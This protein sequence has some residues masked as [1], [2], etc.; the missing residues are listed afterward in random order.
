MIQSVTI[1]NY[2]GESLEFDLDKP[3]K[4]GIYIKKIDGLGPVS[5]NVNM[6]EL[7]S[8]DGA[9]F[10]S[11]R[12]NSRNI[13]IQFGLMFN[14]MIE[15][16]RHVLYRLFPLKGQVLVRVQTDR[17]DLYTT[18]YVET[19]NPD[20]F[21]KEETQQVS[22]LCPTPWWNAIGSH[23]SDFFSVT[24]GFMFPFKND[25]LEDKLLTFGNISNFSEIIID[26]EGDSE[27]GML[28]EIHCLK[29][30]SLGWSGCG[31]KLIN[32]DTDEQLY[33]SFEHQTSTVQ[34]IRAGDSFLISTVKGDKYAV[35]RRN[36]KDTNAINIMGRPTNWIQLRPGK[37]MFRLDMTLPEASVSVS[38][39]QV[40]FTYN[41]IYGGV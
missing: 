22:I 3:D 9:V 33:L 1:T 7:S 41:A 18:G 21:S 24:K 25:S 10:N 27:T 13:V 2:L 23:R 30:F 6:T 38:D 17:R 11:A 35:R 8:A 28:I 39:F 19:N 14:P 5:A 12:L 32:A 34:E 36:G 37:N 20:I 29:T 31:I 15:D 26:Y 4:T 40:S 16:M